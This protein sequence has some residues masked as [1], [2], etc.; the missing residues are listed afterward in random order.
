MALLSEVC[1]SDGDWHPL[2][3]ILLGRIMR[4]SAAEAG[5]LDFVPDVLKEI[6]D[7]I[8]LSLYSPPSSLASSQLYS[9]CI[10][11]CSGDA[12]LSKCFPGELRWDFL[13][14]KWEVPEAA[15]TQSSVREPSMFLRLG[16]LEIMSF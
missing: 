6:N 10:P 4:G 2:W 15:V 8:F 3:T 11:S 1:V 9:S 5:R 7:S 12:L 16:T 13:P 14:Q